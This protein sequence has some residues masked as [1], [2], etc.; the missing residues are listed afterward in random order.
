MA[1]MTARP[2]ALQAVW[3]FPFNQG[4]AEYGLVDAAA[5][6]FR[7]NPLAHLVRETLQNAMD[8]KEDGLSEPVRVSFTKTEI[9]TGIIGADTLRPH[10][11]S[12]L[13]LAKEKRQPEAIA[14]YAKALATLELPTVS[15]LCVVDSG[16]TGLV[17]NNWQALVIQ[18]GVVHKNRPAAGGSNGIGK[19]SA[20]NV[21]D[22]QAIIYSTRYL[23]GRKGREEKLQGKS[24]LATHPHPTDKGAQCQ[25]VGFFRTKT[26]QPLRGRQIPEAF[27]LSDTGAG[28]FVLGFNAYCANWAKAAIAAVLENFFFA[29][30]TRQL[31]VEIRDGYEQPAVTLSH[32]TIDQHLATGGNSASYAYYRAIRDSTAHQVDAG[33]PLG[34]LRVYMLKGE[35]PKRTA[36]L[37]RSGMLITD[38]RARRRNC[39]T[40]QNRSFWPQ[41]AAVVM[42]DTAQGDEWLRAMEN[43]GHDTITPH[44]I[45]EISRRRQ[46]ESVVQAAQNA[47]RE[48][49]EQA[50]NIAEYRAASNLTELAHSLPEL[51]LEAPETITLPATV[52]EHK[53]Q[54]TQFRLRSEMPS[55]AQIPVLLNQRIIST[56]DH[57][58]VIAFNADPAGTV[59]LELQPAGAERGSETRI[60]I[61]AVEDLDHPSKQISLRD[62]CVTINVEDNQRVRIRVTTVQSIANLA[63]TLH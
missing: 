27:R 4:G 36:C 53:P 9:P 11:A 30:H 2:D 31:V 54:N 18:E 63:F 42:A 37:N 62:G 55:G 10:V 43:P 26:G 5:A 13:E 12:C 24:R 22:L 49:Y 7:A 6:H 17:D 25:H 39:L 16:T 61:A 47:L 44:Q 19:N 20:F 46:A 28:I 59:T 34:A 21:S 52:I 8:A 50:F 32:E 56:G 38:S 23:D 1:A 15:C 35:G 40:P 3:Q 48:L 14:V 60:A 33:A 41:Y 29:I 57:D 45:R 58:A 51:P